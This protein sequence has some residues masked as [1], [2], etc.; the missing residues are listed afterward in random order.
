MK[1]KKI[2]PP[3]TISEKLTPKQIQYFIERGLKPTGR[4]VTYK[5]P[6][7][8]DEPIHLKKVKTMHSYKLVFKLHSVGT[9]DVRASTFD[10]ACKKLTHMKLRDIWPHARVTR[11]TCM[12]N[13]P[14]ERDGIDIHDL[15]DID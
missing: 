11:V 12:S 5:H 7:G 4:R 14:L 1:K 2:E 10:K 3:L 9:I 6:G 13:K 8:T 15:K